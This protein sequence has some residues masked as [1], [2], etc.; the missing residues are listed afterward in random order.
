M[1]HIFNLY[2][3][4][5]SSRIRFP[6]TKFASTLD[7][8][9]RLSALV[10]IDRTYPSKATSLSL[11]GTQLQ[12]RHSCIPIHTHVKQNEALHHI[13][14]FLFPKSGLHLRH[15][16]QESG[17]P[18]GNPWRKCAASGDAFRQDN[19]KSINYSYTPGPGPCYEQRD[20]DIGKSQSHYEEKNLVREQEFTP[21][22][23]GGSSTPTPDPLNPCSG[24]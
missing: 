22:V 9:Y 16:R 6:G 7:V 1:L 19:P 18:N 15:C 13:R 3:N 14:D 17:N 24:K 8:Q 20:T 2:S 11:S 23:K 12:A 5:Q 21:L 10:S 4:T